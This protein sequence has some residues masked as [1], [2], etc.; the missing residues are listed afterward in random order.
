MNT[1]LGTV[2]GLA[3]LALGPGCVST[4]PYSPKTTLVEELGWEPAQQRFGELMTRCRSPRIADATIDDK[5]FELTLQGGHAG[6]WWGW[7]GA[8]G[9]KPVIYHNNIGKL[10]IY[11][12]NKVFVLGPDNRRMTEFLFAGQEDCFLFADLVWSFRNAKAPG[13]GATPPPAEG[14]PPP[15]QRNPEEPQHKNVLDGDQKGSSSDSGGTQDE[16]GEGQKTKNVLG[17]D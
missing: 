5:K 14:T 16:S 12:N 10:D 11:E 13:G 8:P 2:L 17:D 6:W 7:G 15:A 3:L 9:G 1:R 4:V